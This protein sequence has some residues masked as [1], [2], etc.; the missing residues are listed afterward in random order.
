PTP[1]LHDALPISYNNAPVGFTVNP[2]ALAITADNQT[3]TYGQTFV[4][5]GTEFSSVGLQNGETVGT[6]T[7]TSAGAAA[8]AHVAG[9]PYAITPSAATGGTFTA[10][11]YTITYNN[12]PVGFTV[13]PA[14]LAVSLSN[15]GVT[16]VYDGTTSA[17]AGFTPTY[18]VS[19]FVAGDT[20]A[21]ITSSG[22]AYNSANVASATTV[23]VSGLSLTG[24]GGSL[25]S[26]ATD[27]SIPS[28][29]GVAA[30]I[31]PKALTAVSLV[32]TVT[33]TYDGNNT[34]S[35]LAPGNYSI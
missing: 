30:T 34:V 27:Y 19:G 4:F 23:T 1:S 13:N 10:G 12:A 22:S 9:S 32:G 2:A 14:A 16:K 31:T 6:V 20:S 8:T 26:N 29:V 21:T 5:N 3:K 33:K 35:N 28:S 15:T 24:I 18:T 7:L 11:D 17:P 25:G